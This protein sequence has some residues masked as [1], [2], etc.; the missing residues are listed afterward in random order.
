MFSRAA[1]L[2]WQK[3]VTICSHFL[4]F[5]YIYRAWSTLL[6]AQN[7]QTAKYQSV[8]YRYNRQCHN[9]SYHPQIVFDQKRCVCPDKQSVFLSKHTASW[10]PSVLHVRRKASFVNETFEKVAPIMVLRLDW[11][12]NERVVFWDKVDSLC[13]N[14]CKLMPICSL[15]MASCKELSNVSRCSDALEVINKLEVNVQR[16]V[17]L[18]SNASFYYRRSV[19]INRT[20]SSY[21]VPTTNWNFASRTLP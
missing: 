13:W 10:A 4:I 11:E 9:Q 2:K 16:R 21:A 3:M 14:L 5:V 15:R 20:G 1:R 6:W 12:P 18:G 7:G 17:G 19:K 8:Y